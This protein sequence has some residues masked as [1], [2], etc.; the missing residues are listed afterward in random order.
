[1]AERRPGSRSKATSWPDP[2]SWTRCSP[3][4]EQHRDVPAPPPLGAAGGDQ[5]GGDSR[6][7]QSAALLVRREK[8]GVG[9]ADDRWIDLR[10]DDHTDPVTELGRLLAL[11]E[12]QANLLDP[13][14]LR[15]DRLGAL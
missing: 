5:A 10:I 6:G 9:G 15:P 8:G 4:G 3:P 7:R 2:R 13:E 11:H 14:K 1:M 12:D